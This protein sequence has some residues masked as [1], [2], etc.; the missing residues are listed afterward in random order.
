MP[1]S[2]YFRRENEEKYSTTKNL[3]FYFLFLVRE[4]FVA[5]SVCDPGAQAFSPLCQPLFLPLTQLPVYSL[6]EEH[7][8]AEIQLSQLPSIQVGRPNNFLP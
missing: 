6:C 4:R 1:E 2:D 8:A 5:S 7:K 3:Y